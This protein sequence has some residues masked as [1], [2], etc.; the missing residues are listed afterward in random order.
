MLIEPNPRL[1]GFG[2]PQSQGITQFNK[3]FDLVRTP[4]QRLSEMEYYDYLETEIPDVRKAL[5]AFTTMATT[6]NLAGG[7]TSSFEIS[8]RDDVEYPDELRERLETTGRL[9]RNNASV[10][11]RN[12]IK[13]GSYTPQLIPERGANGRRGV[14]KLKPIPPGT[15]YRN[16]EPDGRTDPARYWLQV[17]DGKIVGTDMAF[18]PGQLQR[19]GIPQWVLPHFAL[20]TNVVNA[21][22]TLLYGTSILQPFGA[23]GL[24]VAACLDASVVARLSRAAMRYKWKI[25]VSD[26][27]KN[28]NAIRRR[29]QRWQQMVSRSASLLNDATNVD[30]YK[31]APVPDA[32]FFIPSA[33]NLSWDLD[34][35]EGDMNLGNM[36]DVELLVRFY[37]GALGVPPE[38]LG[39]ERSQ[40]GRSSLTQIDIHFARTVRHVQLF[41]VPAFEHIVFADMILGGWDPREYPILVKPPQIGARDDLLQAQIQALQSSVIANL[42][43]A[44]MDPSV[45]PEWVLKTFML[46]DEEL[47]ELEKKQIENLFI[48][49]MGMGGETNDSVPTPDQQQRI[50]Q[51]MQR[52]TGDLMT[53]VRE[54]L[55]LLLLSNDSIAG[56]IYDHSQPTP[57][58]LL[59]AINDAA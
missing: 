26:I 19:T 29:V 46:F 44:G 28:Q 27:A 37:F 58:E 7:G 56:R 35:V 57:A 10:C 33:A 53:V 45:S 42:V 55:R 59:A 11:V 32:D 14:G 2:S 23:I 13:Y 22:N 51:T 48:K 18:T 54:N 24:K 12:M 30:S 5:D 43:A 50:W 8:L 17:I 4:S 15:I 36:K 25:D 16:I 52:T 38:Y 3:F 47:D 9:I 1:V 49:P 6:G 31:R 21:K 41:A 20:W 40:G 34:T 39:H